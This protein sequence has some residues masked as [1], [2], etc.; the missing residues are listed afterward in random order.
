MYQQHAADA[1][2]GGAQLG[3][4][5]C[6]PLGRLGNA[7]AAVQIERHVAI[8]ADDVHGQSLRLAAV[9][10][11][12]VEGDLVELLLGRVLVRCAEIT[13]WPAGPWPC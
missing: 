6:L 7:I 8:L 3:H 9:Q 13:S 12:P 10:I 1:D 11:D 5:A 4:R 2:A